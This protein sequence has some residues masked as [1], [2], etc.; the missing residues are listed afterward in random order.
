M[1]TGALPY[2][3]QALYKDPIYSYL[4]ERNPEAFW[5][6]WSNH[7]NLEVNEEQD[8][9][10]ENHSFCQELYHATMEVALNFFWFVL[11]PVVECVRIL[12]DFF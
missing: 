8:S 3:G 4:R 9:D 7:Q 2:Q 12:V 1:V 11:S 10:L 5:R 6:Q